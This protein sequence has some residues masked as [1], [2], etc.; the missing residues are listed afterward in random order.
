M[1]FYWY[2]SSQEVDMLH[3]NLAKNWWDS[4]PLKLNLKTPWFDLEG[5]NTDASAQTLKNLPKVIRKIEKKGDLKAFEEIGQEAPLFFGFQG[6]GVKLIE[7]DTVL[8]A[9]ARQHQVLLLT[10]AT[11]HLVGG[12]VE[13]LK[14]QSSSNTLVKSLKI[15]WNEPG[16]I[17]NGTVNQ[18][19]VELLRQA[20]D[21]VFPV[22]KGIATFTSKLKTDESA[23]KKLKR[24]E[25][26]SIIVGSPLYIEQVAI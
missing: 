10:G 22:V 25:I 6:A 16:G 26:E 2:I 3:Q 7:D 11:A 4:F 19:V 18:I 21:H 17:A 12:K 20:S 8:V 5:N 24:P 14:L 23:F 15:A 13:S 9:V 1:N